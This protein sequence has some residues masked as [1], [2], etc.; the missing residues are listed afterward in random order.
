MESIDKTIIEKGIK[1]ISE[2]KESKEFIGTV[3][4]K[5]FENCNIIN[6][7]KLVQYLDETIPL[8]HL[9]KCPSIEY[10]PNL[11]NGMLGSY[12]YK[13]HEIHIG[14]ENRFS[15]TEKILDITTHEIGHNTY[16]I[17][18]EKN[19][20]L[21]DKWA[22]LYDESNNKSDGTGFVS[23]L[24]KI[25]KEEDFA[26][27]YMAYIRDPEKLQFMNIDKYE[28]MRD[29]IF[30]GKE[31]HPSIFAYWTYDSGGTKIEVAHTGIYDLWGN[32]I[33]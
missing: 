17:L 14:D 3:E 13:N 29:Y 33:G 8:S 10:D 21:S 32:K 15:N 23:E 2:N 19:K 4:I 31:Y 18:V 1:E 20:E 26:E 12:E 25:R 9:E 6:N 16:D 5:N 7:E 28:F 11:K 30:T 24:S 27:S 22:Q